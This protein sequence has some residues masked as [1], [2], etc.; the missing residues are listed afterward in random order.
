MQAEPGFQEIGG[1]SVGME[2]GHRGKSGYQLTE[3]SHWDHT[4]KGL[5]TFWVH[6]NAK[7]SRLWD[8]VY[9]KKNQS[10]H[11]VENEPWEEAWEQEGQFGHSR[12]C[13]EEFLA[14]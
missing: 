4:L 11:S 2:P 13:W 7:R 9:F 12:G 6:W 3:G 1:K 10:G 8:N 14:V 5:G